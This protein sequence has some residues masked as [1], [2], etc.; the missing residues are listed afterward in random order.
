MKHPVDLH[1]C[2][3]LHNYPHT[4]GMIEKAV[5]LGYKT[6]GA[7]FPTG[8]AK[9][10]IQ[11][12]R[13][14]CRELGVDLVTRVDVA[15]RSVGELLKSLKASRRRAEV[16]AVNCFSKAIARQAAKDRRVDLLSFPSTSPRKHFFDRAEA[17]LASGA[18]AALEIEMTPLLKLQGFR[19]CLLLSTLRKEVQVAGKAGVPVVL[20][21]GADE[22][23]LLRC[24]EDYASLSYLFGI[25]LH[26]AR[27]ALSENPRAII[28]R[29]RKKLSPDFVSPGVY[30]VRRGKNC[31]KV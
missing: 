19:R 14:L 2:P 21:S 9:E 17:K 13:E 30:I 26:A 7:A 29:N 27:K 6:L 31:P 28:D 24:S 4:R 16:V 20:S 3:Q 18:L 8:H 22:P 10:E 1:L 25:E 15:P 23:Y 5:E 11:R 12:V